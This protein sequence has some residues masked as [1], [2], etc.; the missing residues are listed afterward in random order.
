MNYSDQISLAYKAILM[1][2][3]DE[4]GFDYYK[5]RMENGDMDL[6]S[7]LTSLLSSDERKIRENRLQQ[8]K[9]PLENAADQLS[10]ALGAF[11][12]GDRSLAFFLLDQGLKVFPDF[13]N[14]DGICVFYQHAIVLMT[15]FECVDEMEI[16]ISDNWLVFCRYPEVVFQWTWEK[17]QTFSRLHTVLLRKLYQE[18]TSRGLLQDEVIK[19]ALILQNDMFMKIAVEE[20]PR[21]TKLISQ[22]SVYLLT[23]ALIV[24][25]RTTTALYEIENLHRLGMRSFESVL[26]MSAIEL[27]I[28]NQMQSLSNIEQAVSLLDNSD[29]GTARL[30][31]GVL[32]ARQITMSRE[33]QGKLDIII[34]SHS[35]DKMI[36]NKRIGPPSTTMIEICDNSMSEHLLK[37]WDCSKTLMFDH[38]PN[39]LSNLYLSALQAF[40]FGR[41]IDM[42]INQEFGLRRQWLDALNLLQSDYVLFVEQDFEFL[43][44]S[45]SMREV[46]ELFTRRPDINYIRLN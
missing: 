15:Q 9:F 29:S 43:P 21:M 2:E 18:S 10:S 38:R 28:G 14:D 3:A 44:T 26:R 16:F 24:T 37:D 19:Q 8:K 35:T 1:R 6:I 5:E 45:P 20:I 25:N 39:E 11:A 31:Q 32:K 34:F 36:V 22:A 41:R 13:R 27:D 23:D 12:A 7:V 33:Q 4:S 46:M 40:C 42:V 30:L 17:K